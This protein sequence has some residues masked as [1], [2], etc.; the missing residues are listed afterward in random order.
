LA[1]ISPHVRFTENKPELPFPDASWHAV[2]EEIGPALTFSDPAT[3][4]VGI[5][6]SVRMLDTLR[7]L[8]VPQGRV[9]AIV[10]IEH[11]SRPS[12]TCPD[13]RRRSATSAH[14]GTTPT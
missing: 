7:F 4:N 1:P 5:F 12:A 2:D 11:C 10:E 8:A 3:G 6:T 9:G 13:R 14:S